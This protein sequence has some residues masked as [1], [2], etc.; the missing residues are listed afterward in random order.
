M[1]D[2]TEKKAAT[3]AKINE[4]IRAA[5]ASER[6]YQGVQLDKILSALDNIGGGL[7]EMKKHHEEMRAR[8][9]ALEKRDDGSSH[10]PSKAGHRGATNV[11][12]EIT[13][14]DDP[15]KSPTA[16][17]RVVADDAGDTPWARNERERKRHNQLG[18]IQ[19]E[20]SKVANTWGEDTPRHMSGELPRD[21]SIRLARRF[22]RHCPEF[23]DVDLG[24]LRDSPALDGVLSRI[25]A[26]ATAAASTP[27]EGLGDVLVKR[28]QKDGTGR[29][30]ITWHGQPI[31]WMKDFM[32]PRRRVI[33]WRTGDNAGVM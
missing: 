2:E 9:D 11:D 20:W 4:A 26:D 21:Y 24:Q 29:E 6:E 7:S 12:D 15:T 19:W 23:K 10:L 33:R 13:D 14:P 1:P 27:A 8:L 30:L 25:R 28:V 32:P 16:P 17:K 18:E 31:A 3:A 5:G 22:Q